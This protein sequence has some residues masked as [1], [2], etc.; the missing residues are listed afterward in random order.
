MDREKLMRLND[1]SGRVAIVTGGTRGI[2]LAIA[3][4]LLAAGANV[5]VAS[6]KA[7]ACAATEAHL[8]AWAATRSASPPTW[9][10][11]APSTPWSIARSTASAGSTSS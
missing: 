6:R 7:E 5:V 11:S 10:T 9:A 2:G 8:R 1:L 4:G 3:E